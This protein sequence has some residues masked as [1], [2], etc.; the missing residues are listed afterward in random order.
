MCLPFLNPNFLICK[1]R[2][3]FH[4]AAVRIKGP[5]PLRPDSGARQEAA[6]PVDRDHDTG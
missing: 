4:E 2:D 5:V 3:L 1:M 6:V